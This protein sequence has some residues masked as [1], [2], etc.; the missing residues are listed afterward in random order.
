MPSRLNSVSLTNKKE[1]G[2]RNDFMSS[3]EITEA[4][5]RGRRSE[6]VNVEKGQEKLTSNMVGFVD[7]CSRAIATI[8]HSVTILR[9][10]PHHYSYMIVVAI[11]T[12]L[13]LDVITLQKASW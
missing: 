7:K 3:K 5:G 2:K 8:L 6:L 9:K 1:N 10:S 11:V 13:L 12:F 4:L